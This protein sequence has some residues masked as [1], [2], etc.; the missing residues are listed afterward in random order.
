MGYNIE[1]S[2]DFLKNGS[3]IELLNNV[4]LS[5]ENYFCDDFYEDYEF[6]THT[7][8]QRRHCVITINF[9]N[10][11]SNYM[12]EFLT[13]IRK[14]DGLYIE[15]IYDDISDSIIYASKYFITQKMSKYAVKEYK[16]IYGKNTVSHSQKWQEIYDWIASQNR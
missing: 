11:K 13:D 4:R 9:S 5:A 6:D 3:L 10:Q 15:V 8:F 14:R 12:I 7:Q 1:L 16:P 2:F